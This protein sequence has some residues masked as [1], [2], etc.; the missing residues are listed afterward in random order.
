VSSCVLGRAPSVEGTDRTPFSADGAISSGLT[1]SMPRELA[2]MYAPIVCLHTREL[3]SPKPVEAML[4]NAVLKRRDPAVPDPVVAERLTITDLARSTDSTLYLTYRPGISLV[5]L[6]ENY[7][8]TVYTRLVADGDFLFLQFRFFYVYNDWV[9]KHEGDWEMIQI[10]FPAQPPAA[11]LTGQVQ[12]LF[13]TYSQHSRGVSRAWSK[14]RVRDKTHPVVYVS[15]GSHA[16]YYEA[17]TH[18]MVIGLERT[19]SSE[20]YYQLDIIAP[21]DATGRLGWLAFAG[22]WGRPGRSHLLSEDGPVGPRFK[23]M[24]H[25]PLL[26][27]KGRIADTGRPVSLLRALLD[28]GS[29]FGG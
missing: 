17:K 1:L 18:C 21:G 10:A 14:V 23:L 20:T 13:T 29:L 6:Q 12:P 8:N 4:D 22:R 3:Y 16:N 25:R 11:I 27:S 9:N 2:E 26:W 7:P 24:W 19:G 5:R 28:P 15:L